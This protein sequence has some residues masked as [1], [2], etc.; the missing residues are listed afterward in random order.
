M[1]QVSKVLGLSFD[2][3]E[4]MAWEL[5]AKLEK[6]AT[7]KQAHGKDRGNGEKARLVRKLKNLKWGLT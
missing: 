7:H 3:L 5:F 1:E 2:G 4:Q 6:R